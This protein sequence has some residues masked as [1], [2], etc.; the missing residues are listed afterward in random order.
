MKRNWIWIVMTMT[1]FLHAKLVGEILSVNHA[2]F[3]KNATIALKKVFKKC[4]SFEIIC[5]DWS[6]NSVH[7]VWTVLAVHQFWNFCCSEFGGPWLSAWARKRESVFCLGEYSDG[8]NKFVY[9]DF[10]PGTNGLDA[11]DACIECGACSEEKFLESDVYN[12]FRMGEIIGS[13]VGGVLFV[14]G[15]IVC[16][17]CYCKGYLVAF[18]QVKIITYSIENCK[19]WAKIYETQRSL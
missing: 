6:V 11:L 7:A 3:I 15:C 2:G 18:L 8:Y 10:K 5:L 19:I 17:C 12:D 16:C 14:I 13:I 4:C 9:G 1:T